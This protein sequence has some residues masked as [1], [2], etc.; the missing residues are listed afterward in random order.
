MLHPFI[1]LAHQGKN[2]GWRYLAG[3]L[4]ALFTFLVPGSLISLYLLFAYVRSDGNPETR[5]L[6]PSELAPG[7][8]PVTG[9]SPLVLYVFYNLAFPFFLLG[10]YLAVRYLH[11]RS[12]RTLITPFRRVSW[13]R[14]GQGFSVFFMLK[15]IEI[16]VSYWSAPEEFTLNVFQPQLFFTFLAWVMVL[17]PLQITAEELFCRGYLLQGI[18]SKL[19]NLVAVLLTTTLFTALHGFNPEVSSQANPEGTISILL[20]YFMVGAFLGWLTIKDKTIELALGVHAANN[21][22][23]FLLVTSPNSAIPSPAIFSIADIEASFASLFL[24]AL[25]LFVFAVVVFRGFKRPVVT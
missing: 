8:I 13:L 24:T 9:V 12:L 16:L 5:L 25:L 15:V 18:G 11:G 23:T 6:S 21:I 2:Q 19:G 20:Y 4:L 14:I 3:S 10:I 7:E 1:Q 17:T 22:A